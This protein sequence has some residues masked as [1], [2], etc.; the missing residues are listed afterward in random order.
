MTPYALRRSASNVGMGLLQLVNS[1]NTLAGL[2][3][4]GISLRLGVLLPCTA[5][6]SVECNTP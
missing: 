6:Y 1:E 2:V 5:C 4:G 3:V